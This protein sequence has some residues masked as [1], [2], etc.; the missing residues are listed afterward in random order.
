MC[1]AAS[2][3]CALGEDE[4]E[5]PNFTGRGALEKL[6]VPEEL[7]LKAP[8]E[9]GCGVGCGGGGGWPGMEGFRALFRS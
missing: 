6:M 5:K 3:P 2:R 7:H 4:A 1:W 8:G 9:R